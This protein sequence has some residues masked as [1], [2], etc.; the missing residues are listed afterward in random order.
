MKKIEVILKVTDACNLRCKYCYNGERPYA[1]NCL[2]A[3]HFEKLLTLLQ[4]GYD[5]I[6]IIWH[7]GEP[8]S[9]G[10]EY[11]RN[12]MDIERKIHIRSGVLIENSIQTN[13]TLIDAQ[14]IRFFQENDFHVGISFDGIE[15]EKYRQ[16]T[17]K[18]EKAMKA[19]QDAGVKFGCNA[20]VADDQY[21]LKANYRYFA[22]KCISFDFSRMLQEGGAK[23]M[24]SV[25]TVAY[26]KALNELFDEWIYD[27]EGV[28]IRTFALY[29]N[30]ACGGR[31]RICST[32]SCHM[33][34]LSISPDG[35]LYNCGRESLGQYPFGSVEDFENVKDVFTCDNAIALI[36]GSIARR[37]KCKQTCEYFSLC[38]GG[39]PDVA[40]LENGLENPPVEYCY[41][42]KTVYTHVREVYEDI[43]ARKVPLSKL[44]PCVKQILANTLSR[45]EMTA[46]NDIGDTY[47]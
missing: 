24:P 23:G 34:Y 4:T 36:S 19:L 35:T 14:W 28:S 26:A 39:C 16:Q 18:T 6:H 44:N 1:N 41:T 7:G 17:D 47:V 8:L 42:F 13:G 25:A 31:Y 15:N 45:S 11:Y 3:E 9:V 32:C 10:L 43:V 27:T 2:S 37:E 38:A 29:L 20:V 21:D 22:Q 46:K 30:M 12:A 5:L 33:K 40:I